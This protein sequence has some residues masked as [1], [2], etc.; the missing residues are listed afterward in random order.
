MG[1]NSINKA[2]NT[3]KLSAAQV[4]MIKTLR[5]PDASV[6]VGR[7][8]NNSII[9]EGKFS[10]KLNGQTFDALVKKQII[11]FKRQTLNHNIYGLTELG[12]TMLLPE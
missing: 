8:S 12:R 9:D 10:L 5:N 6:M 4:D 1:D 3:L 2:K 11:E 7:F